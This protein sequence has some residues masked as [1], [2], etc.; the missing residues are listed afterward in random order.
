MTGIK[1][2]NIKRIVIGLFVIAVGLMPEIV[3]SSYY[4]TVG[5]FIGIYAIVAMGL[6]LLLGY[7]GQVSMAQAGF[8]GIGGYTSAILTTAAGCNPWLAAILGIIIA[9]IVAGIIGIPLLKLEG[10]VLA[11]ATMGLSIVVYTIFVEWGDLTG[12]YDG[13]GGI[14]GLSFFGYEL[15]TDEHYYYVIWVAVLVVFI[16]SSNII[17]S[18]V[19]RALRS[20]HRFSGGSEMAAQSLG[21]S[22]SKYKVQVFILSAVYA[23]LAGSLYAH[24]VAFINPEPF[25]IFIGIL[26][27]IMITIGGMGSLWGAI[28]GAIVIVCSGEF[29]RG[30]LPKIIPG[31]AGEM[32]NIAY[33]MI[34]VL[35]LLF[36]PRGLAYAPEFVRDL[37]ARITN[38]NR[39]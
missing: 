23:S 28:I 29:F 33:G 34:L 26:M 38:K 24:W 31:A 8:F 10:H 11:V 9:S 25:G 16:L 18:R 30:V 32:E 14:P 19:G 20:I 12:G 2:I 21:V 15:N 3:R 39:N 35:I 13:I 5:N 27:L 4:V 37:K 17:N 36:M 1:S 7:A 6:S 22:P